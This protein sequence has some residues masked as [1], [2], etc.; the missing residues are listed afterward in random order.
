MCFYPDTKQQG[1]FLL[2]ILCSATE[3]VNSV[4]TASFAIGFEKTRNPVL[5][6][7]QTSR[8]LANVVDFAHVRATQDKEEGRRRDEWWRRFV[9]GCSTFARGR[10]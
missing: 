4:S 7:Q 3:I 5:G 2:K 1:A 8:F 6:G 9:G 10:T